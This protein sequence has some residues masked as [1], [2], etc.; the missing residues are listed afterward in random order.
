MAAPKPLSTSLSKVKSALLRPALTSNY[1]CWFDPPQDV[2]NYI[3]TNK[4]LPYTV[5]TQEQLSLSCY[6]ASLPGSSLM[7]NEINDDYTGVTER[8]AYR[9]QYDDRA[10]F[11]FY[12]DHADKNGY[13]VIWFFEQWMQYIANEQTAQGVESSNFNYRFRFPDSNETGG[14]TGYRSPGIYINK[15]ERDFKGY[16]LSYKLLKAYPVAINSMPV[17]YES[18]DL[19]RCTVSFTYTRYTVERKDNATASTTTQEPNTSV[20]NQNPTNKANFLGNTPEELAAAQASGFVQGF[21]GADKIPQFK[22]PASQ[23][24]YEKYSN[25]INK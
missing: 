2:V 13:K 4:N 20:A 14:G 22:N 15:F 1:Q 10:D 21:G 9:R 7:T 5:D 16:Y 17:S 8:L 24:I 6:E 23:A 19:L 3:S 18:S 12:V 11:T 25:I